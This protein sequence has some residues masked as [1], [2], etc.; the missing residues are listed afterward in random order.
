MNWLWFAKVAEMEADLIIQNPVL[1]QQ[2]FHGDGTR[3]EAL[4][5]RAR[6]PTVETFQIRCREVEVSRPESEGDA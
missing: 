5:L 2:A 1:V 4:E 3:Q 6:N